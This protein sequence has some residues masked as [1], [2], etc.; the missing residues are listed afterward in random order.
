MSS[1]SIAQFQAHRAGAP[2]PF[3][4]RDRNAP[5]LPPPAEG[6]AELLARAYDLEALS[7]KLAR[8]ATELRAAA[9]AMQGRD[10]P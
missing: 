8:R 9:D 6:P 5:T 7:R 2:A 1:K 3:D 10:L 4:P